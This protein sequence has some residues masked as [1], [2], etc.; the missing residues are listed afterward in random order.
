MLC[1]CITVLV[2][3]VKSI[4]NLIYGLRWYQLSSNDQFLVKMIIQ[5][6]EQQY[7]VRAFGIFV[8]SLETFLKVK[9][10]IIE[11]QSIEMDYFCVLS[12]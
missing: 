4:G 3:N 7:E 2:E 6:S 5:R 12:E 11:F 1:K 9:I 10:I 8:C